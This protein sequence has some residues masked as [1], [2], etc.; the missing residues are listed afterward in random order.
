MSEAQITIQDVAFGGSGVGRLPDGKVVFVPFTL[1]GETV[2][3]RLYKNKKGFSEGELL[4][5]V[6]PSPHR[7]LP[8]CPYFG[9]CG[10]C[11]YQHAS[12]AEQLKIKEKQVRDILGRI[13][14]FR[15]L[16][17]IQME[18]APRPFGYRNKISVHSGLNGELG[19]YAAE[20]RTV[21]D[22]EEC[23]IATDA[24][25]QQLKGMRANRSHPRHATLTDV[26]QREDTPEGSFHQVNTEMAGRLL[27]WVKL[28]A[29]ND[30][31]LE[32]IDLYCGSGFF[33]LAL[34][35]QFKRVCGMDRDPRAIDSASKSA[36]KLGLQNVQFFAA[37]VGERMEWL[38]KDLPMD[39]Q[40]VLVD[41]PREGLAANVALALSAAPWRRL[42]YVACDPA[43]LARDLKKLAGGAPGRKITALAMFDM[44]PQTMHIEAGVVLESGR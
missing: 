2:R 27:D 6:I 3:V 29:G 28:Q 42:V 30:P 37:D 13:G 22:V 34:A 23:L 36:A 39:Q 40:V 33:S 41:P 1:T 25:N 12:H 16:P 32:L 43:T 35:G 38:L 18:A 44:F 10:G 7:V 11:Q 5:V 26:R 8:P 31:D 17:A 9:K 4:E 21:V 24:I 14:G 19:F 15:S 20:S